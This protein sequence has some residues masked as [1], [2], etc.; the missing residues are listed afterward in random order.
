MKNW[1]TGDEKLKTA[2]LWFNNLSDIFELNNELKTNIIQH[3]KE[4]E[5][6]FKLCFPEV[7]EMTCHLQKI[8]F[9]FPLKM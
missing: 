7:S 8:R 4:L 5:S 6:E 9:D 2:F 1:Q 3:L